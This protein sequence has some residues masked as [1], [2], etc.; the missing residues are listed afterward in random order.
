MRSKGQEIKTQERPEKPLEFTDYKE[1]LR[2]VNE[3]VDAGESVAALYR[4]GTFTKA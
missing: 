4:H 1:F 3:R 2:H